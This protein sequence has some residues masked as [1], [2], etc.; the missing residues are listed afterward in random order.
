MNHNKIRKKL[1]LTS[2]WENKSKYYED[3]FLLLKVLLY[4]DIQGSYVL[5]GISWSK[6]IKLVWFFKIHLFTPT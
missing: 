2:L 4:A 5:L 6:I 1:R 3:T